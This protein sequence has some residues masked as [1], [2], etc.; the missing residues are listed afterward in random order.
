MNQG[1]QNVD[2]KTYIRIQP[3]AAERA[4]KFANL[5]WPSLK[6]GPHPDSGEDC[7]YLEADIRE[8]SAF[9]VALTVQYRNEAEAIV[10]FADR[11]QLQHTESGDTRFW[12]PGI[13]VQSV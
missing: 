10:G 11:V 5:D 7:L 8:Y 3:D 1:G 4:L 12:I 2:A 13:G 9:L 6:R